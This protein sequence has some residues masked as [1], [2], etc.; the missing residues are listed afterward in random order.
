MGEWAAITLI[1]ATV[2]F[3]GFGV[4]PP[5]ASLGNMLAGIQFN[6]QSAPWVAIAPG[7]C[8]FAAVFGIE[9]A[10]RADVKTHAQ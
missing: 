10:R 8:L 1:L 3:F 5:T 4:Q 6:A 7:V 2:D 9:L